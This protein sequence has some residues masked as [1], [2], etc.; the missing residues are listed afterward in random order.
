MKKILS[1]AILFGAIRL[2]SAGTTN[3]YV[4]DWGTI[5][6]GSSVG[7]NGNINLVG[8]TGVAVSQSAGPYLGI[9]QASGASDAGSGSPLPVNTVYFTG[10]TGSQTTPGMFYTTDASGAGSGGD[11]AFADIDP[12]QYTNLTFS[13]EVR[14]NA[15][16]DTNYFAIMVGGQWY[17]STNELIGSGGLSYPV[18]TNAT[19]AFTNIASAWRT[20]T[21]NSTDVTIGPTPGSNLSGLIT[22]IGI[23]E[24]PG[25]STGYNYNQLVVSAFSSAGGG[26]PV[27]PNVTP[28][29]SPQYSYPGGGA[30]FLAQA[31]GTPPLTFIWE[32]NGVP[33]P[34][35]GRWIG[36]NSNELTITNLTAEDAAATYSLVVTN[37]AGA[38]TNDNLTLVLSNQPP[39]LL[40]AENFPYVGPNGN[41]PISGVGWAS[42]ASSGTSVGIYQDGTGRGD[43]F[44]FSPSATT[45]LYYTT[46]T[47]DI[48]LSGLP[49]VD[50]NPANYPA[51]TLQA[52]FVPGN[53]AGQV[54][55]A[56][57]VYWA[58]S[59]NGTWYA[60]AAPV[61]VTLTGTSPFLTYQMGFN[62]AATNWNTL[63]VTGTNAIIGPQASS[64]LT[65][66]ITGAGIVIAHNTST[67]SDMNFQNFEITTN[68]AVGTA[69]AIGTG[70]PLAVNVPSG[71]GA[72]FGVTANGT[73][74]FTYGWTTNGVL[75]QNGG[76]VSGATTAT[77]T[78][79][80]LTAADNGMQVV[81]FVTNS[82]GVDESDAIYGATPVTV[83]NAPVGE[84]YLE[85]FPFVG[86]AGGNYP[87]SGIGWSEAVPNSPNA[88]FQAQSLT[89]EG[90]AFA[91][92]GSPA[93]TVYY[94]STATDTNQS[95]LPFPNIRLDSY[96]SLNFSV[97]I[98]PSFAGSNVTAYVAVQLNG[99]NW[100]VSA[101]PLPVVNIPDSGTYSTYT[102][103][104]SPA[105]A[106]W[107][108]LTVATSGGLIGATATN[109][110][111]GVVT[112]AG[113]VFVTTGTGG[114]F[115]FDNFG[116]FGTGL[117]GINTGPL[118]NGKINLTWVGNPVVNL[119]SSTNLNN[120]AAWQD[121]TNTVG[122]YSWPA[123]VNG[124]I[125]FYRLV[126]HP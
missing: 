65:G 34:S 19:V 6:G 7:G 100:Y 89:G 33:L 38:V 20:L 32:S 101:S 93:T 15:S 18:F 80:D 117:G 83:T 76:R 88:L 45:N 70:F 22:G 35:G 3:L 106:N 49:F 77:L 57:S 102:M 40:Y 8:W 55:G 97:D 37:I 9:Y 50:I 2:A 87:L 12:T 10:L 78:I 115:N 91:F 71:G 58:V 25:T 24:L 113:L 85:Q 39:E 98:A 104:F 124:P 68:Q 27:A 51:V 94:T 13:V 118:A 60:S 11:S 111:T 126:Q 109:N 82:A 79:A 74:P 121:V 112:G 53:G 81:A 95:G 31:S 92:L 52:N 44:S 75:V 56:I 107:K 4:Q 26:G 72:S 125:Q 36:V 46:D 47:N 73:Q 14:G 67:G 63:T 54:A 48:G 103:A 120:P 108:N 90:A 16:T 99:T 29:I 59:M 123:S 62:P 42:S 23:V 64:D 114:T 122:A 43:V 30:S 105:A 110:L 17:V 69:P 96:P 119:Q 21:I 1:L 86:P 28:A 66:N 84:I 41:L 61:N 5:K 116:I